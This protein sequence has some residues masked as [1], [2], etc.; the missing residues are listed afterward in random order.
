MDVCNIYPQAK[1]GCVKMGL[2]FAVGFIQ[3]LLNKERELD[4][5]PEYK[6]VGLKQNPSHKSDGLP[7]FLVG[8]G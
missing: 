5:S 3:R 6:A 4:F 7:R 1:P 2:S 8:K